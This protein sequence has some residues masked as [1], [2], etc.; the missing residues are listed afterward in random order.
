MA[1]HKCPGLNPANFKP[2]DIQLHKCIQ[3][4]NELEFWKDD[5]KLQ[6]KKCRQFNF[7]PNMGN[8]CLT[9]CKS[10]ADCL[11]Q[12]DINAWLREHRKVSEGERKTW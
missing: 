7:N 8:T 1:R 11:G 6:C 10:A 9:Y 4:G 5:I 12:A 3:C 2:T